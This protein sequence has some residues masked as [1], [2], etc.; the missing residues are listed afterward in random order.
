MV[1]K[2]DL[3]QLVNK[4]DTPKLIVQMHKLSIEAGQSG[5]VARLLTGVFNKLTKTG[6]FE[7]VYLF[8]PNGSKDVLKLKSYGKKIEEVSNAKTSLKKKPEPGKFT[9]SALKKIFPDIPWDLTAYSFGVLFYLNKNSYALLWSARSPEK[10]VNYFELFTPLMQVMNQRIETLN[11][12]A[13]ILKPKTGNDPETLRRMYDSSPELIAIVDSFSGKILSANATFKK[14][15]GYSEADLKIRPIYKITTGVKAHWKKY[16][17]ILKTGKDS[18]VQMQSFLIKKNRRRLPVS[19]QICPLEVGNLDKVA[20]FCKDITQRLQIEEVLF[21]RKMRAEVTLNSIGDAVISTDIDGNIEYLNPMA[22]QITG[23]H[24]TE[25]EGMQ[26]KEILTIRYEESEELVPD[27]VKKSLKKE[28]LMYHMEKPAF[29]INR[30]GDKVPIEFNTS[31]LEGQN[32]TVQGIVLVIHDVTESRTLAQI[33]SWQASHDSLTGLLNRRE[34]EKHLGKALVVSH[35]EEITSVMLYIDLDQFKVINDLY[36]HAAGDDLLK[37]LCSRIQLLLGTDTIFA[38]L[39]GDEFGIIK[40]GI[41][42]KQTMPLAEEILASIR[43]YRF[44]SGKRNHQIGAC[45]GMVPIEPHNISAS[46]IMSMAD[47]ACST[48]KELGRN[49]IHAYIGGDKE[50]LKKHGEMKWIS[51][52]KNAIEKN[53]FK[54]FYQKI[55]PLVDPKQKPHYE[56]LL[57]MQSEKGEIIYPIDFIAAAERYNI[58]P[59]IDRWVIQNTL[60]TIAGNF[61]KQQYEN[62]VFSIN[63][64]GKSLDD[65]MLF[66]FVKEQFSIYG[67]NPE[68]FCFEITENTAISNFNNARRFMEEM[69]TLGSSF[70][71]DDFGTGV[72]SLGYLKNLPVD[73]LKIDGSFV[74]NVLNDPTELAMLESINEIGHVMKLKTVAE[75]VEN[76]DLVEKVTQLGIDYGQGYA[77]HKP[78]ELINFSP[79]V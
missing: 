21:E 11:S 32:G 68:N 57:R 41:S 44:T 45:I 49:R 40:Y 28:S 29:L 9:K 38:R 46:Q 78:E 14:V 59:E 20:L 22:E 15:L 54:L 63:L 79:D 10:G 13:L 67:L 60:K 56:V 6:P 39:G 4:M 42:P 12:Q 50:Y 37:Q 77:I 18:V 26:L 8:T 5:S 34:F 25:C 58:M 64:T 48:A 73:L 30:D 35:K 23:W 17:S 52:I 33:L 62:A 53:E 70:A 72:S 7:S 19:I 27:V 43:N 66:L 16:Y 24:F 74:K 76:D 71:L 2:V 31:P 55:H 3:N 51:S 75:Y 36:G 61:T 65:D 69:K 1:N 47:I